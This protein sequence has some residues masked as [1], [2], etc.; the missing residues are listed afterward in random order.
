MILKIVS[1]YPRIK[2][3][4][5]ILLLLLLLFYPLK[6][7]CRIEGLKHGCLQFYLKWTQS[8]ILSCKTCEVLQNFSFIQDYLLTLG[9][10]LLI[11]GHNF[12]GIVFVRFF[13]KSW[14]SR[15]SLRQGP[16]FR[17]LQE[18]IWLTVINEIFNFPPRLGLSNELFVWTLFGLPELPSSIV[19][20][21]G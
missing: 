4:T 11:S 21:L 10:L 5:I 17:K 7:S 3:V 6:Y 19:I 18:A 16:K 15:N 9:Q 1:F 8:L 12:Y 2:N 20:H 14:I 13:E